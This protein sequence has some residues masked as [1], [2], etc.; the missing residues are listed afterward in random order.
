MKKKTSVVILLLMLI[1]GLAGGFALSRAFSGPISIPASFSADTDT[2]TVIAEP[3]NTTLLTVSAHVLDALKDEDWKALSTYASSSGV[4]F[5]PYSTVDPSTN[6]TFKA[7]DLAKAGSSSSA[8]VWGVSPDT[9]EPIQLTIHDYFH[10]FVW[11]QD[12]TCAAEIGL[13]TIVHAGNCVENVSSAYPSCHYLD[14]YCPGSTQDNEDW[15][16]LKL[17]FH[18]EGGRWALAAIIH[19]GWTA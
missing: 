13:D 16:S 4:T 3:N 15:S 8:F 18:Y 19:S 11:D 10:N 14:F 6:L 5:T 1:I 17:V 12:Y 2:S 7:S 9:N